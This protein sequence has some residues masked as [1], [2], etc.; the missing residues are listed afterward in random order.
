MSF[1]RFFAFVGRA[2]LPNQARDKVSK[3]SGVGALGVAPLP[4]GGGGV[5]CGW[6]PGVETGDR[7]QANSLSPFPLS[8][9]ASL[10]WPLAPP[11]G[12]PFPRG[13]PRARFPAT[14]ATGGHKFAAGSA[15]RHGSLGPERPPPCLGSWAPEGQEVAGHTAQGLSRNHGVTRSPVERHLARDRARWHWGSSGFPPS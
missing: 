14:E 1:R 8:A 7:K 5:P 13:G 6:V 12:L 11:R 10:L 4:G 15:E 3:A 2:V 9:P